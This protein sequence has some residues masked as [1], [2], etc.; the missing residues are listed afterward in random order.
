MFHKILVQNFLRFTL[1]KISNFR[2]NGHP[3][4]NIYFNFLHSKIITIYLKN[5]VQ[6][7]EMKQKLE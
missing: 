2:F 4:T 3:L 1:I 7:F 5:L 6:L